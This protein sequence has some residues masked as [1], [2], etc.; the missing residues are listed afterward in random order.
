MHAWVWLNSRVGMQHR[1]RPQCADRRP[2]DLQQVAGVPDPRRHRHPQAAP[3]QARR[4]V[5]GQRQLRLFDARQPTYGS[6]LQLGQR[7]ACRLTA[8]GREE[9]SPP[10][11]LWHAGEVK[12][13]SLAHP[14]RYSLTLPPAPH[15]Q[16]A[17]TRCAG[18]PPS[19]RLHQRPRETRVCAARPLDDWGRHAG[20]RTAPA[21]SAQIR[22]CCRRR[23]LP[24]SRPQS[25]HPCCRR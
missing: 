16:P 19:R 15:P 11:C 23:R 10:A 5:V 25:T 7:L 12:L 8:A 3:S 22:P 9:G 14:S 13:G 24:A 2:T 21:A 4:R 6:H 20:C 1:D 17:R 18:Q